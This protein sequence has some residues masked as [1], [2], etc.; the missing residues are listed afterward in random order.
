MRRAREGSRDALNTLLGQCGERLLAFIRLRLGPGL[1]AQ[2]ESGD[3]LQVTLLRGFQH[4]DQFEGASSR[5]LV[6]WLMTIA[7]NVI[8][9]EADFAHRQR[10]D[11]RL[12]VPMTDD[13]ANI[14]ADL[15]SEVSRLA[16]K[17]ETGRLESAMERLEPLH[18]GHPA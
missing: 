5:S 3:I 10:R 8:R 7:Q 15:R 13:V 14:I 2:V 4:I 12:T 11:A 1:R 9:D 17:E 6:A 16:L 18:R